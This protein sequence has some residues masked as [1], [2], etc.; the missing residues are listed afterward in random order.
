MLRGI[1]RERAACRGVDV[2]L[3]YSEIDAEV[4]RAL[5]ICGQCEVRDACLDHAMAAEPYGVWGGLT[6]GRRRRLVRA[7]R[8]QGGASAPAA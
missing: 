3:F 2:E 4:R 5:A 6:E 7:R 1:W 8:Q